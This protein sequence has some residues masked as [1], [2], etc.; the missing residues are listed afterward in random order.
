MSR[1]RP[2]RLNVPSKQGHIEPYQESVNIVNKMIQWFHL[3]FFDQ[4]KCSDESEEHSKAGI[5]FQFYLQSFD[6]FGMM[7]V[8]MGIDPK[9]P[10]A[11]LFHS[12][13]EIGRKWGSLF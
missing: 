10:F 13:T 5:Q 2:R 1:W 12:R 4:S 7:L 8:D 6:V 3:S 9:E 11:N